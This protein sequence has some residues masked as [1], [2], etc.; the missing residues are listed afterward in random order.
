MKLFEIEQK[1]RVKDPKAVR[2]LLKKFGA[3]KIAGGPEKNE[4]FDR[5]GVLSSKKI[6][7]RLRRFG[8]EAVLALKGPRIRSRFTKRMEIEAPVDYGPVK[9]ILQLSVKEFNFSARF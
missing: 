6:A 4:F 2:V 7:M 9:T 1:Y 5:Q 3:Q 8:K